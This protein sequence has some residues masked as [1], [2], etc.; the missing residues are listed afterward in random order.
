ML[1]SFG[2]HGESLFFVW[3]RVWLSDWKRCRSLST[4]CHIHL[5]YSTGLHWIFHRCLSIWCAG[6]ST[7][8]PEFPRGKLYR[9]LKQEIQKSEMKIHTAQSYAP[10]SA[11]S[12]IQIP[13]EKHAI[14]PSAFRSLRD[15]WS[16]VSTTASCKVKFS[17]SSNW[18]IFL[19]CS[20]H[21]WNGSSAAYKHLT[22]S[23]TV[24]EDHIA[25]SPDCEAAPVAN[26]TGGQ[27]VL[28]VLPNTINLSLTNTVCKIG[29]ILHFNGSDRLTEKNFICFFNYLP[30]SW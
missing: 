20:F 15:F 5:F 14:L 21:Y 4:N 23:E 18:D 30:K 25:K 17:P 13:A 1:W 9:A 22:C 29:L 7:S 16:L 3:P 12:Q 6:R 28:P 10:R 24:L 26:G 11:G 19:D 27:L 8:S 2:N